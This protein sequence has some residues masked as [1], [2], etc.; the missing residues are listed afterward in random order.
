MPELQTDPHHALVQAYRLLPQDIAMARFP[1][2]SR[3]YAVEA[4]LVVEAKAAGAANNDVVAHVLGVLKGTL[5]KQL[6]RGETVHC[7]A[8][9]LADLRW[10]VAF[11]HLDMRVT[12]RIEDPRLRQP[13]SATDRALLIEH[14][15]ALRE[16]DLKRPDDVNDGVDTFRATETALSLALLDYPEDLAPFTDPGLR[17]AY[18]GHQNRVA[19]RHFGKRP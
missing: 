5:A 16:H 11:R 2:L 7:D 10:Q 3:V 18:Q 8:A 6:E 1:A 14:A 12:A 4:Q 17:A 13:L 19:P 15:N 9:M